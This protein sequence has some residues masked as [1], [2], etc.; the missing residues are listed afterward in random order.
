MHSKDNKCSTLSASA[1]TQAPFAPMSLPPS[2]KFVRLEFIC[3]TLSKPVSKRPRTNHL[4]CLYEST[5]T[6]RAHFIVPQVESGMGLIHLSWPFSKS[7]E[8]FPPC[9]PPRQRAHRLSPDGSSPCQVRSARSSPE[10][11]ALRAQP[12]A[13]SLLTHK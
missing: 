6:L 4:E 5:R 12:V 2:S 1:T 13:P 8:E 11:G 7:H 10:V 9:T 3:K